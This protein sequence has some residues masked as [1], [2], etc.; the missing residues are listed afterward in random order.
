M[1]SSSTN[2]QVVLCATLEG[3]K[4]AVTSIAA[5]SDPTKKFIVSGSRGMLSFQPP[6]EWM[7]EKPMGAHP[8]AHDPSIHTRM[9]PLLSPCIT[10][11][12]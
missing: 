12:D 10:I 3:H 11:L 8:L 2:V 1:D 6:P 4:D 7:D 9:L 5:P